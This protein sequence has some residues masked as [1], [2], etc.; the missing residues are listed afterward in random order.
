MS[1]LFGRG[2]VIQRQTIVIH[3]RNR[4][5]HLGSIH[6]AI[7]EAN[8]CLIIACGNDRRILSRFIGND[9]LVRGAG[10]QHLT[11]NA[12]RETPFSLSV[13]LS[14]ES[15]LTAP[16]VSSPIGRAKDKFDCSPAEIRTG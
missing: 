11:C 5:V 16:S 2:A 14:I 15:W 9:A 7:P 13:P 12:D 8:P 4:Q 1:Q 10:P 3:T 6:P